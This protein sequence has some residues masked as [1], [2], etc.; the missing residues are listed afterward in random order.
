MAQATLERRLFT[1][2]RPFPGNHADSF[3]NHFLLIRQ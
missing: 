2:Q 3:R 1:I